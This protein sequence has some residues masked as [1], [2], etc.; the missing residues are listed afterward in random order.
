MHRE[1]ACIFAC[2]AHFS[3]SYFVR[4][5]FHI[6]GILSSK[7]G[8]PDLVSLNEKFYL[9]AFPKSIGVSESNHYCDWLSYCDFMAYRPSD[10]SVYLWVHSFLSEWRRA[11]TPA[12]VCGHRVI[13]ESQLRPKLHF[14][15]LALPGTVLLLGIKKNVSVV[16]D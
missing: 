2:F 3:Q 12:Q 13:G 9:E 15:F 16:N 5:I 7:L 8:A 4:C 14:I 11:W 10:S 1:H 6:Q